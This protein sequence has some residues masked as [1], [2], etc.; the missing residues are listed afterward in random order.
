L[1]DAYVAVDLGAESGRVVLGRYDGE[2]IALEEVH[3]FENRPVRLPDGTRWNL[4]ALFAESLRG[5]AEAAERA[6]LRGIGVDS[7]GVD[8]ALL[9]GEDRVLG[10]PFHY[11]D[12]RTDGMIEA[13]HGLVERAELYSV[14]GIQTMPI[15]TVFQLMA[16]RGS[17]A[18]AAAQRIAL[19]PDLFNLW[20]TG[21]LANE[22]TNASTTGL[23]DARE[24]TWA[25]DI[26]VRLGL[27]EAPFSGD[28]IE[29]GRTLAAALDHHDAIGGVPV[30]LVASHDT[31]SAFA[32]A[33][34]NA[35]VLSSGTW[36]LLGFELDAPRLDER[37]AAF[38]LTNERGVDG[39]IR[40][41]RNVMG[42]WLLQECRREWGDPSYDELTRLAEAAPADVPLFDPD[43]DAFIAPG[44]MPARIAEAC[45]RRPEGR[46]ELV[47]SILTSLACRYRMVVEQLEQ[48]SERTVDC[49][50]MIGGGSRSA[51]LCRLTASL[52]GRPVLAG[53]VEATALGNILVQLRASGELGSREDMRA[54]AAASAEPEI[55]E[56]DGEAAEG[57]YERFLPLIAA[58]T[59]VTS[60]L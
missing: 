4:M 58:H 21:V 5:L 44:G 3:R 6:R 26:V 59:E 8:Y 36:S 55:F 9:D 43:D 18:L 19:V 38:N 17:A 50:H 60:S 29:P 16:D 28:P 37:A 32:A 30:H 11:R 10:L 13:A 51:P 20:L 56:P 27:P 7:W 25:R 57:I 33:R 34:A 2:R 42:L 23:L 52:I 41:L 22:S 40:L 1:S 46:G 54:V 14:T 49:V 53:P 47:R 48:T 39:T 45:D 31:A 24:A 15:N 12:P 35:A